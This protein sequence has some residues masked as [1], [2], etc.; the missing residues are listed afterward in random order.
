[1]AP[2][3]LRSYRQ[4]LK[5]MPVASAEAQLMFLPG[6][7]PKLLQAVLRSAA[8]NAVHNNN[9]GRDS[10]V[11]RDVIVDGAFTM[12]RARAVSRG[13]SHGIIKRSSH[14]TVLVEGDVTEKKRLRRKK[15]ATASV[16]AE[17]EKVP[18]LRKANRPARQTKISRASLKPAKTVTTHRR[19]SM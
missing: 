17:S 4:L 14:I 5:G 16:G 3:K 7:V 2:R 9:M 19:K 12:K 18:Q 11:V 13:S 8:A 1:M 6:K 10:L 15:A